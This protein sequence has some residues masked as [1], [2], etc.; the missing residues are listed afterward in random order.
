MEQASGHAGGEII[1][2][3]APSGHNDDGDE[4]H[5]PSPVEDPMEQVILKAL[6]FDDADSMCTGVSVFQRGESSPGWDNSEYS[7]VFQPIERTDLSPSILHA[8]RVFSDSKLDKNVRNLKKGKIATA[9]LGARAWNKQ[10][11]RLFQRKIR[12]EGIDDE[13]VI[14]MDLS[15]STRYRWNASI[16]KTA[17]AMADVLAAVGVKFSVY[18]H[19]TDDAWDDY[20]FQQEMYLAKAV[21]DPWGPTQQDLLSRL[22]GLEGSLDGHNLEFYRKVLMRSTARRKTLVYYTDGRI[23]ETNH[24]EESVIITRELALYKQLGFNILCVAFGTD[25]PKKYGLDTIKIKG[26]DDIVT[27][28]KELEKRLT[29]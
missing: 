25:G 22:A 4:M 18:G 5:A 11:E 29:A 12:A 8:R 28:I 19:T 2:G 20:E 10:D 14:G 16:K 3:C 21:S 15:G 9:K 17:F 13:I 7:S 27:V 6:V 23:P 24:I 26:P 1:L